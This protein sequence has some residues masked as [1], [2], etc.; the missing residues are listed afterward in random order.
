MKGCFLDEGG[1]NKDESLYVFLCLATYFN[2]LYPTLPN[3]IK[4][5]GE[6]VKGCRH[7]IKSKK[8]SNAV[9]LSLYW[10]VLS[11]SFTIIEF[12]LDISFRVVMQ[13]TSPLGKGRK[14]G[15]CLC[16]IG[17]RNALSWLFAVCWVGYFIN[18]WV[19]MQ[20]T[21]S[22]KKGRWRGDYL[23]RTDI[24]NALSWL[25]AVCWVGY[26]ICFWVVMQ[27]TSLL[28]TG[29]KR[30]DYLCRTEIRN[31]LSWLLQ[32]VELVTL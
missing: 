28:A 30:G 19:V 11:F 24:R 4:W 5:K 1:R 31:A 16:R 21:S 3:Q 9:H 7:H 22:F 13:H 27:H 18:F 10:N 29:R 26:F 23:C 32:C 8:T 6:K 12:S 2:L 14:C 17:V 25:F 15:D 20:H